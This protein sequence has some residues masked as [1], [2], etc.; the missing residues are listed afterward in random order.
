MESTAAAMVRYCNFY[1]EMFF[2]D[3]FYFLDEDVEMVEED[4]FDEAEDQIMPPLNLPDRYILVQWHPSS[5][6]DDQIISL[7]GVPPTDSDNS[8]ATVN[9]AAEVDEV[10][11][12]CPSSNRVP[13][14]PFKTRGEFDFVRLMIT[15]RLKR[16]DIDSLLENMHGNR[17][18]VSKCNLSVSSYSDIEERLQRARWIFPQVC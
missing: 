7:S 15:S 5:N 11:V 10:S 2:S 1:R 17:E 14:H 8:E 9:N 12:A 4:L 3:R 6:R 16:N 13:W 18:W